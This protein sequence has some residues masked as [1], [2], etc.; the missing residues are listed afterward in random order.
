M[1]N[2]SRLLHSY[3]IYYLSCYQLVLV[4]S[5]CYLFLNL[6]SHIIETY[7][8][9]PCFLCLMHSITFIMVFEWRIDTHVTTNLILRYVLILL[10]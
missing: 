6:P 5:D 10:S 2:I 7:L 9:Q 8:F 4:L 3:N 1:C